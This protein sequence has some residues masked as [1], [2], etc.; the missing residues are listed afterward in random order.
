MDQDPSLPLVYCSRSCSREGRPCQ[1]S[2]LLGRTR[3][4]PQLSGLGMVTDSSL[5]FCSRS[6]GAQPMMLLQEAVKGKEGALQ[7]APNHHLL[8]LRCSKGRKVWWPPPAGQT[9]RRGCPRSA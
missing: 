4:P 3:Y 7:H 1:N 8:P 6:A 5:Y 2:M 9:T